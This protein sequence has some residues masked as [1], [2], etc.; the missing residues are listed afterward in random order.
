M[1]SGRPSPKELF[2]ETM[3]SLE[4][5]IREGRHSSFWKVACEL[6]RDW[7]DGHYHVLFDGKRICKTCAA[8]AGVKV[9]Q[10]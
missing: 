5:A 9:V 6:C 8:R 3:T 4:D 2:S 10:V 7:C 1:A